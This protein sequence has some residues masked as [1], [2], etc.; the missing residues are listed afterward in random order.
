MTHKSVIIMSTTPFP[1]RGQPEISE[2]N[3]EQI[4][5]ENISAQKENKMKQNSNFKCE[6]SPANAKF[7]CKNAFN[8]KHEKKQRKYGKKVSAQ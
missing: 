3:E 2:Q 4:R 5:H 1:A 6:H 8:A 7:R